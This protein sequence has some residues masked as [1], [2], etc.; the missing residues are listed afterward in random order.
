VNTR[1]KMSLEK[2]ISKWKA[3]IESNVDCF[4]EIKNFLNKHTKKQDVLAMHI[5]SG[6][7]FRVYYSADKDINESLLVKMMEF[8]WQLSTP[9]TFKYYLQQMLYCV[10]KLQK[11]RL[12]ISKLLQI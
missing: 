1:E 4:D 8:L 5:L 11:V 2:Q 12:Q 7:I 6:C 9:D 3:Q 10:S